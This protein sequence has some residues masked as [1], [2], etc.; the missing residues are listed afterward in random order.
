MVVVTAIVRMANMVV[1]GLLYLI[2]FSF[3][4]VD[5]CACGPGG[6]VVLLVVKN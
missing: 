4:R 3:D 5:V 1:V 6:V 2:G